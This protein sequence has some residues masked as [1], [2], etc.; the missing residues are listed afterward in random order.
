MCKLTGRLIGVVVLFSLIFAPAS[1]GFGATQGFANE[2]AFASAMEY[3]ISSQADAGAGSLRAILEIARWGDVVTF[4]PVIFPPTQP[5]TITLL[6]ALPPLS[7]GKLTLDASNAG[8]ILDGSQTPTGSDGLQITSD[9]NIVRGLQITGFPNN[10]ISITAG[11]LNIIGGDWQ[12]GPAARGQGNI[13]THNGGLGIGITGGGNNTIIGNLVG[14]DQDGTQ[15]IRIQ[16]SVF[17]PD[18]ATDQTIFIGTQFDGVWQ[19]A[20]GGSSWR[21]VNQGLTQPNVLSLAISPNYR[22]DHTLFASTL[23]GGVFKSE[24]GG[25]SWLQVSGTQIG[26]DVVALVVSPNYANDHFVAAA[27]NVRHKVA[28]V[29]H[30]GGLHWRS[31]DQDINDWESVGIAISPDFPNDNTLFAFHSNSIVRSTNGG[32]TWQVLTETISVI[33]GLTVSPAYSTDRTVFVLGNC[34]DV[35]LCR[36]SDRGEHWERIGGDPN[37]DALRLALAPTYPTEP[38]LFVVDNLGV[39]RSSDEGVNWTKVLTT[40]RSRMLALSPSYNQDHKVYVEDRLGDLLQSSDSGETWQAVARLSEH[41]NAYCGVGLLAGARNNIIGGNSVGA[42]NIISKNG[43]GICIEGAT[44]AG[45]TVIGNYIG[46]DASGT[47]ADGNIYN[48][49]VI[50]GGTN[51]NRVGGSTPEERNVICA[52]QRM[53]V[54]LW[55]E[56]SSAN[57]ISGNYIGLA[58]TGTMI[59]GNEDTGVVLDQASGNRIGGDLAGERNVISGNRSSGVYVKG[60]GENSLLG[61]YI[62]TDASGTVAFGNHDSGIVLD[63]GAHDNRIE[64]NLLSGNRNGGL[65]FFSPGTRNNTVIANLVG[66]NGTGTAALG[67]DYGIRCWGTGEHHVLRDNVVSGNTNSGISWLN[68]HH[69][70]MVNNRVG[71]G[72]DGLTN[73]GNGDTGLEFGNGATQN[74]VGPGNEITY[75]RAA[76][77]RVLGP[78]TLGNRITRNVIHRNGGLGIDNV[79]GGGLELPPPT[80]TFDTLTA[81]TLSGVAPADATVE[82]FSDEGGQGAF[83]EGETT[84]DASGY[85]TFVKDSGF[86]GPYITAIAIDGTGNTSE[87]SSRAGPIP[88]PVTQTPTPTPTR[89]PGECSA[90]HWSALIYL[91]GDN[92]LDFWTFKLFNRLEMAAAN[93]CVQIVVLWDRSGV[94][95]TVLYWVQHDDRPYDL[96]TYTD[97]VNRWPRGELNMGDPQTLINFVTQARRDYPNPRTFLALVDHGN[98]WAPSL[99]A[100]KGYPHGGMSF[101][102]NSGGAYLSTSNLETAFGVITDN[103]AH[104]LDVLFYDACLMSMI[105]NVHPIRSFVRFLVASQNESFSSYPYDEYLGSITGTTQPANLATTIVDRY[106]ESLH[107]YPRTI[108]ALDLTHVQTVSQAVDGL[109]RALQPL[110][111]PYK[112]LMQTSFNSAQKFDSNLDLRLDNTD[113][114]IDLYHFAQLIKQNIPEVSSQAAA[115]GVMDAIGASGAKTILKERHASGVYWDNGQFWGLDDAHGLSIYLP[116]GR[117]DWLLDYYGGGELSFAADTVWDEF[118][119]DLISAAQ[120]GPGATP[121]PIDADDRP[122]PL[123]TDRTTKLYLPL[124]MQR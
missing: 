78:E 31:P 59:L 86:R 40:D 27:T 5:A 63:N 29:S 33:S 106:H 80:I 23:G 47:E 6:S 120:V 92:N 41:G 122:G 42:R 124:L 52:N 101:D 79:W 67:N 28:Y 22:N 83:Y 24:S 39:F 38:T 12:T 49:L 114:Y 115:Q 57:I 8:V 34:G 81:T 71:L 62:G 55:D 43:N 32:Q 44:T 25:A 10:G 85:F 100:G 107:G 56:D 51:A 95:D 93:Q 58:A 88:H 20:D 72:A 98:G 112:A 70:T 3:V 110:V 105:E 35:G 9:Q 64:R 69:A 14:L 121:V 54:V 97:Q 89:L 2:Q 37:W 53:G 87:F 113:A 108:V 123:P 19:S 61:N 65:D 96:A 73:L 77:V 66:V 74:V 76:G 118:V 102:D 111:Q 45:N 50:S 4:D 21:S 1:Y 16:A 84:A 103:G 90:P 17:S 7:Q 94:G 117:G 18:F 13:L 99:P 91:N 119:R 48:G 15:D 109:A 11:Y 30:D 104:P 46:T 26:D 75:N 60:G 116:L 82:V 68:C 36:S